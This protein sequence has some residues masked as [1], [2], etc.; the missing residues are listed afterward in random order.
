MIGDS[1]SGV[2]HSG[3]H[4]AALLLRVGPEVVFLA[5]Y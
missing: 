3:E 1:A 5:A 2:S 4:I